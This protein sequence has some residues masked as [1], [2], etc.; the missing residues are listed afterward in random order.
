MAIGI[1][2]GTSRQPGV[3][4]TDA[5]QAAVQDDQL[6]ATPLLPIP[7]ACEA[8]GADVCEPRQAKTTRPSAGPFPSGSILPYGQFLDAVKNKVVTLAMDDGEVYRVKFAT[9]EYGIT[10]G[11]FFRVRAVEGRPDV[12]EPVSGGAPLRLSRS[13]DGR[14]LELTGPKDCPVGTYKYPFVVLL[15]MTDSFVSTGRSPVRA[16]LRWGHELTWAAMHDTEVVGVLQVPPPVPPPEQVVPFHD[17]V[18]AVRGKEIDLAWDDGDVHRLRFDTNEY[19]VTTASYFRVCRTQG[20]PDKLESLC[21]PLTV[22][23]TPDGRYM[24]LQ[25]SNASPI[26]TYAHSFQVLVPMTEGFLLSGQAPVR[27]DLRWGT[28]RTADG[29]LKPRG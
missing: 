20:Q 26:G 19:G 13:R 17:F 9:N 27:A 2:N 15:P 16:N 5:P 24:R 3:E 7:N 11:A 23:A 29:F 18:D 21:A 12:L 28:L 22:S 6:R 4:T 10:T 14:C 25:G 1:S 8:A